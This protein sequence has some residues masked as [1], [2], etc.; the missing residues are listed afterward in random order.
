MMTKK[1]MTVTILILHNNADFS[2]SNLAL[3]IENEGTI[4]YY[5]IDTLA[6]KIK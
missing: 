3:K 2:I 6:K 5:D 4:S 1:K